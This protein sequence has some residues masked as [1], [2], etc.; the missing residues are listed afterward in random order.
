[1]SLERVERVKNGKFWRPFD[2]LLYGILLAFIVISFV[3]IA[4]KNASAGE[5]T[6]VEITYENAVIGRYTFAD[7]WQELGHGADVSFEITENGEKTDVVI[8]TDRGYNRLTI[9]GQSFCVYME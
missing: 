1:M 7:G 6:G 9:Y 4:V 5:I 8:Y 3:V 2:I